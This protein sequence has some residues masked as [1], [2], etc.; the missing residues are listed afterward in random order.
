[1]HP[2]KFEVGDK[3][4]IHSLPVTGPDFTLNGEIVIVKLARGY[5]QDFPQ[6]YGVMFKDGRI[7]PAKECYLRPF[8]PSR[9][10]GDMDTKTTWEEFEK[11]TGIS[12]DTIRHGPF[13]GE[14][15]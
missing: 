7:Q 12:V 10:R 6:C 11:E 4:E 13:T 14:S 1:M 9:N 8:P 3:L 2:P 5:L 15:T